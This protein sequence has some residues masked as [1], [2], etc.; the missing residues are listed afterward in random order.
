VA[1]D[2]L[3]AHV[4]AP[5]S[6][7]QFAFDLVRLGLG[8]LTRSRHLTV[9]RGRSFRIEAAD[10]AVYRRRSMAMRSGTFLCRSAFW[11]HKTPDASRFRQLRST[12]R[13]TY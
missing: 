13:R 1:D 5:A 7:L 12:R 11:S 8:R 9:I 10:N 2:E 4:F 3:A 6:R